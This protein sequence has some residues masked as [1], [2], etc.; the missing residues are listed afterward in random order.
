MQFF[1]DLQEGLALGLRKEEARVGGPTDTDNEE[2]HIE[3]VGQC[4]LEVKRDPETQ[5]GSVRPQ[6]ARPRASSERGTCLPFLA[7]PHPLQAP[8]PGVE[9]S[10]WGSHADRDK[11]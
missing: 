1:G 11:T 5:C 2:R 10:H 6:D 8:S 7:Q 4:L 3:E 9:A